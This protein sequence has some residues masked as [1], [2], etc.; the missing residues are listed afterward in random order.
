[1][2]NDQETLSTLMDGEMDGSG[3][4]TLGGIASAEDTR[5]VWARYH[6]IGDV[7]RDG[8]TEVAPPE[9]AERLRIEIGREPTVLAPRRRGRSL[10]RPAAGLAIA[11]SVAALAVLGVKQLDPTQGLGPTPEISAAIPTVASEALI[12]AESPA[13]V[14]ELQESLHS[15]RRLNSYLVKFNEQRLSLG[16]PGVNPY[17][18]IV[19]FEPE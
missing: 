5:P 18:R 10:L 12:A 15:Q 17:V 4:A 9:F 3:G 1:M 19:G 8:L 6:L 13:A 7:I 16:V 11:A 14:D 2:Q